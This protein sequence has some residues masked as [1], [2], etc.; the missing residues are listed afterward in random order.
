MVNL[1]HENDSFHNVNTTKSIEPRTMLN[2]NLYTSTGIYIAIFAACPLQ[3]L[4]TNANIYQIILTP[5]FLNVFG[6][7]A[8]TEDIAKPQVQ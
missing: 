2:Q 5:K 4:E 3:K 1:L 6:N 8:Q 7:N